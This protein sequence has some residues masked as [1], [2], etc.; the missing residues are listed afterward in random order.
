MGKIFLSLVFI[1]MFCSQAF[2]NGSSKVELGNVNSDA[3]LSVNENGIIKYCTKNKLYHFIKAPD[4]DPFAFLLILEEKYE[5]QT[6]GDEVSTSNIKLTAWKITEN[7]IGPNL[8]IIE[9][10]GHQWKILK[11]EVIVINKGCCDN[12]DKKY[13]FDLKTGKPKNNK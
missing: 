13:L 12:P 5:S 10:N 4:I 9:Q 3:F 1:F 8:W 6:L 7:K 2:S 11:D